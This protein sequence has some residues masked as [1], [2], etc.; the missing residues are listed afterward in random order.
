MYWHGGIF[1]ASSM[2]AAVILG[3]NSWWI[4]KFTRTQDSRTS[5]MCSTS[6]FFFEKKKFRRNSECESCLFW[7]RFAPAPCAS[8]TSLWRPKRRRDCVL[9]L[10]CTVLPEVSTWKSNELTSVGN[11]TVKCSMPIGIF[12]TIMDE[13]NMGQRSSDQMGESKSLCLR[14]FRSMCWSDGTGSRAAERR[15]KS[16]VEDLSMYHH[17]K[18]LWESMEKQLNSR[19]KFPRNPENVGREDHPRRELRRP[20]HLH[21]NVQWHSVENRWWELHLELWESQ[22]LREEILTKT[23]NISGSRVGKDMVWRL[24][25]WTRTVRSH[26]QQN[27]TAIQRNCS[28]Y[29]HKYQHL[30]TTRNYCKIRPD[31][32]DGWW[33]FTQGTIMGPIIEVH[34][35]KIL[36]ECGIE[37]RFQQSADPRTH[38]MLSSPEKMS[39]LWTKFINTKQKSNPVWIARTSSRI[40]QMNLTNNEG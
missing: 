18:M 1:M 2:K 5:R 35:V 7:I 3:W 4:R 40:R 38:L 13:I 31:D 20:D 26:S 19:C 37:F 8:F 25:R 29:L 34:I 11:K 14:W 17:I 16:Q 39:A 33:K 36:D 21:V 30:V 22:E 10:Y 9:S 15:W 27:G 28:S 12:I 24:S 32:D 23:L 6:L